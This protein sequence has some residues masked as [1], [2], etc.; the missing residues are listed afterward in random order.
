MW[1]LIIHGACRGEHQYTMIWMAWRALAHNVLDDLACTGTLCTF[2]YLV[3][4][5]PR[6]QVARLRESAHVP[7]PYLYQV[8]PA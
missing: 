2:P 8:F 6:V 7:G 1:H 3:V 4:V 5:A